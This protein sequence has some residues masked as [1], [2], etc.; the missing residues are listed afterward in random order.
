MNVLERIPK[1]TW[2]YVLI[3]PVLGVIPAP[4]RCEG[5][6][7]KRLAEIKGWTLL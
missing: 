1:T 2:L 3:L 5:L 7:N 4:R 6:C